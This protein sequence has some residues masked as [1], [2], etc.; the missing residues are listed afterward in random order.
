MMTAVEMLNRM[1]S[2]FK[3][4]VFLMKLRS[5]SQV[6]IM[7]A[8]EETFNHYRHLLTGDLKEQLVQWRIK[9]NAVLVMPSLQL[10]PLK[11]PKRFSR[12]SPLL[13]ITQNNNW[14]IVP[15]PLLMATS[16][17]VVETWTNAS[18]IIK[19]TKLW[20]KLHIHMLQSRNLALTVQL[21]QYL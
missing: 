5:K 2:V 15:Q 20:L 9:D 6:M 16:D 17:V 4:T 19:Q 8:E 7:E 11:V 14:L 13:V 10:L 12:E 21:K 1:T 3:S 18:S